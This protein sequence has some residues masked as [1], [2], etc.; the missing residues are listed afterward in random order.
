[1]TERRECPKCNCERVLRAIDDEPELPDDMPDDMYLY[2][3]ESKTNAE[4]AFRHIVKATKLDIKMRI[5][6]FFENEDST[7]D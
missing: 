1:M 6:G 4:T 3:C 7:N 2:I 5:Q